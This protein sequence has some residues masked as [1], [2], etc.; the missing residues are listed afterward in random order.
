MWQIL[1]GHKKNIYTIKLVKQRCLFTIFNPQ[2]TF[3]LSPISR[4]AGLPPC[5]LF[6]FFFFS[7]YCLPTTVRPSPPHQSHCLAPPREVQRCETHVENLN[8]MTMEYKSK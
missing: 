4:I 1:T 8:L 2:I 6:I 3:S 5:L 7:T